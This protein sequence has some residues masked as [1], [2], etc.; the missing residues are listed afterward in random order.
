MLDTEKRL[1]LNRDGWSFRGEGV[2]KVKGCTARVE[3]W[4]KPGKG[5]AILDYI[6]LRPHWPSC[7]GITKGR[8]AKIER[9]EKQLN[10][11]EGADGDRG[12]ASA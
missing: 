4:R 7:T 6:E 11:F 3:Y 10:L 2:C 9:K 5:I 1:R 12:R 8:L